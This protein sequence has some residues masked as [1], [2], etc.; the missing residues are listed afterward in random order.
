MRSDLLL[1]LDSEFEKFA[2][3]HVKKDACSLAHHLH[4]GRSRLELSLFG[5]QLG[6]SRPTAVVAAAATAE[7]FSH[8]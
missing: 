2:S 7:G 5:A 4:E 8:A 6:K 3:V 1:L